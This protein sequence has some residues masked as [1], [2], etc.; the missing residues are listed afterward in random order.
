M[1]ANVNERRVSAPP[2]H[3][4]T[5]RVR[6]AMAITLRGVEELL[7]QDEWLAKLARSQ[8]TGVP[9]R[10]KFGMDPTAP[11]LHLGIRW[12]STRCA[13]CRTWVTP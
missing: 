9:L 8:A 4:V 3:P 12:S 6:E 13:S 2:Q 10:I 7:P 1:S 5:D 11:D